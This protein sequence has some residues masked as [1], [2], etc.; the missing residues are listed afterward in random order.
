MF[1]PYL[2]TAGL[3]NVTANRRSL[4]SIMNHRFAYD[5]SI[6]YQDRRSKQDWSKNHKRVRRGTCYNISSP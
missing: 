6:D 1:V 2:A 3:L 5:I 4:I